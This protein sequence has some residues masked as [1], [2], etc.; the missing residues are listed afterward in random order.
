MGSCGHCHKGSEKDG[1]L[2]YSRFVPHQDP[3]KASNQGGG[4]DHV[5]QGSQ[6]QGK[7]SQDGC[8]GFP[9][10]CIESSD[11]E[12]KDSVLHEFSDAVPWETHGAGLR[13]ALLGCHFATVNLPSQG[14]PVM[15]NSP[16]RND[17][18]K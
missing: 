1:R 10:G 15:A 14:S 4:E 5:W 11:L 6:S 16:W 7:A 18:P 8:E 2:H 9:S 17:S 3:N 13:Q 12:G